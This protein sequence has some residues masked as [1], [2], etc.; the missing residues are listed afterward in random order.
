MTETPAQAATHGG[1]SRARQYL[2]IFFVLFVLTVLEVG[3]AYLH[4]HK[5]EV[6]VVLFSLAAVKA[7]CVALFFMHLKWETRV[8]RA[9]VMVPLSLPVLYAL[10]LITEA[11][12][13]RLA[14]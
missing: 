13:R 10:V 12:W 3:V 11:A 14:G 7:A 4:G 9:T 6:V 8:L 2:T 1:A 5:T